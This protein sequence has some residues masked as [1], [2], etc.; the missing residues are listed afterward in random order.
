M[1]DPE[2][3]SAA[4]VIAMSAQKKSIVYLESK[5]DRP[6]GMC[7]LDLKVVF[8]GPA[9][10]G[11]TSLIHR[12]CNGT[13]QPET[14]STIGAGFFT[15][16]LTIDNSDVNLFLWDT[17][18]EERFRS[19][20]PSLLRGANGLV[21]VYDVTQ[22]A[23]FDELNV[24][25]EMFLDTVPVDLSVELPVLVLGNKSDLTSEVTQANVE[26]WCSQKRIVHIF[27]VS[28]KSGDQ[29]NEAMKTL[30]RTL[31]KP[32]QTMDKPSLQLVMAPVA[33][34]KNGCC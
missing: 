13:F 12:Y 26:S 24:Y 32:V 19:V 23:T 4:A 33:P 14:L 16:T 9:S 10:V 11:K 27:N 5:V 17:A 34:Q 22:P 25:L 3:H 21:L 29:V 31:M 18:G 28:A 1:G 6:S 20:A 8:L 2:P 7:E 15:Q 30:I